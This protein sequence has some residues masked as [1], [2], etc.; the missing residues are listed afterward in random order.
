MEFL[1]PNPAMGQMLLKGASSPS[2]SQTCAV[3][4]S[5]VGLFIS[6]DLDARKNTGSGGPVSKSPCQSSSIRGG[7]ASLEAST[8]V[9]KDQ[10]S[11][12]A[13]SVW[14]TLIHLDQF[15]EGH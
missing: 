7:A 15:S 8:G 12:L 11:S 14:L 13:T 10:A 9:P 5:S 2:S 6:E 1:S 4:H 3:S